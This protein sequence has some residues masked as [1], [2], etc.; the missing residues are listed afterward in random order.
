M[1]F[2]LDLQLFAKRAGVKADLLVKRV[3]AGVAE[4]LIMRSP[5]GDAS[6]WKSPPPKGY[7][8]GRFRGNWDY[9]FN[10]PQSQQFEVIDKTGSLS[11]SRIAAKMKA[12]QMA[13]HIH[14]ITNSLPYAIR[15][16][17]GWSRQA[18]NGMVSLTV[19]AFQGL[20]RGAL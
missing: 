14:Y 16:E 15:L 1:S 8:G 4:S 18:P 6:Y 7:T 3:V 5:V 12:G 17:D 10:A 2:T 13:G 20:V 11:T 9:G 19:Q